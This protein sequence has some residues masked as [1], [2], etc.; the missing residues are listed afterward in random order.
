M[1]VPPD[2]A[3]MNEV[4]LCPHALCNDTPYHGLTQVSYNE[5]AA[6]RSDLTYAQHI[7]LHSMHAILNNIV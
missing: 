3:S 4:P 2:G 1:N 5:I 7:S 6:Q